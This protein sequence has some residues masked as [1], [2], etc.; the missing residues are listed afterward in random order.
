MNDSE[1]IVIDNIIDLD[2]QEQ[3]K[4]IL[5]GEINYKDYEFPW[6]YT[7][8]VTK[9]DCQ[10]SQKRPAFTHGYVK[11]SGIVISEFHD[12]FLNL[13]KVCCHRL[14]IKKVDVIQGRSFLQLPL[15]TKKGKV[16]TPHIDTDD[17]HFVMLYYVVD[18][19]GDTIIYNEKVESEEYTIKKSVTPK[20]GRVVLFDGGLYHT[21]EQPTK[22]TR[23]VVNYNLV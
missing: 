16:D 21:A 4:S 18:S 20:Q 7:K 9:S 13:I 15:T 6:Y 12:V 19:D 5:L 23:C 8:D 2:Y 11:L 22:D 17:K 10:D 1:I 14:Q 3:I